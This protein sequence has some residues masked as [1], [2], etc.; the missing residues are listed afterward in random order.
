MCTKKTSIFLHVNFLTLFVFNILLW[1]KYDIIVLVC[2]FPIGRKG[3]GLGEGGEGGE[4][5]GGGRGWE[6]GGKY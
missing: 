2:R 4:G 3:G 6:E 1:Y 5:G